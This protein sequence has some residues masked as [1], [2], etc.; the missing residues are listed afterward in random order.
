MN[1]IRSRKNTSNKNTEQENIKNYKQPTLQA[2]RKI[3]KLLDPNIHI[4][5]LIGLNTHEEN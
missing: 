4:N 5:G 1:F 3:Q 2:F